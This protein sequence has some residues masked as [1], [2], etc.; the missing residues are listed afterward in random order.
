M[1][2][3]SQEVASETFRTDRV[4]SKRSSGMP[5]KKAISRPKLKPPTID[6]QKLV[7]VS[8]YEQNR[9]LKRFARKF[10]RRVTPSYRDSKDDSQAFGESLFGGWE[11]VGRRLG[12]TPLRRSKRFG[13]TLNREGGSGTHYFLRERAVRGHSTFLEGMKRGRRAAG[14]EQSRL[15]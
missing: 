13:D 12:D 2:V 7:L 1:F 3:C 9:F 10:E 4:R 6:S 8:W 15:S 11:T 5:R 14:R